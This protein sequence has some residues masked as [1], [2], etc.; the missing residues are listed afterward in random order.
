MKAEKPRFTVLDAFVTA[1]FFVSLGISVDF[2]VFLILALP[3]PYFLLT[4]RK[5][6]FPAL[7]LAFALGLAWG[8]PA[9]SLYVYETTLFVIGPLNLY[10]ICYWTI[11][12]FATY[13]LFRTFQS[14][15][16][17]FWVRWL[18]FSLFFWSGLIVIEFVAYH[19]LGLKDL[20]TLN[21]PGLPVLDCIHAPS[22]MK[23]VYFTMGPL[24]F[25]LLTLLERFIGIVPGF[26]LSS[27]TDSNPANA[28]F[29]LLARGDTRPSRFRDRVMRTPR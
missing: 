8:I 7:A 14:Y 25:L 29:P 24:Y 13:F 26:S 21:C 4:G 3:I 10:P 28:F 23:V 9:S 15:F 22:T 1:L 11:G 27:K 19:F 16:M 12:L 18:V 20:A 2:L 6:L 5:H 17:S